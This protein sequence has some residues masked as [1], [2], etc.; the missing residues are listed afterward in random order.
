MNS[1]IILKSTFF[2]PLQTPNPNPKPQKPIS[3]FSIK[4]SI[5]SDPWS[6][7]DGNDISK[8]KPRSRNAKK[9]LSD[10]N[11][12]RIIK[13]K[14]HYLSLLRKNKG[15]HVQTPKWIKRTPEQMVKYLEDHRN[16]QIYGK[17]VI[18]A[19]KTVRGM[20]GVREE[21]RN[22]RLVMSGFVSKLTFREMCVVLKEQRGWREA[23]DFF[24]WMKLQLCYRPCV[25]VYTIVLRI[26]GQV[27]KI[28]L[29]EQTFLEMLESGCEPDEVA[30][31]TMLC[32][33]ARWGRHKA[34]LS[35]YSAIQERGIVLS[36]S[37]YNFMLSSLQKK[38]LHGRVIELWRQM[39]DKG[40]T[41]NSFTYTVVISSLVKDGLHEEAFRMFNEMKN[42]GHVP[43][44]V[45]YSLLITISTKKYNWDE[46]GRLY[47]DLKSQG[48]VPSNFTCA[49]LLTMYYK[50]G[51]FSKA[52]SLFLEMQSKRIPADE[53]IYG[54]LIRIYGKLGL[55]D[56][57]QKIFEET[58]ELG[59]LSDE[60]TYL[61]MA[62]VHLNS[63]NSEKAL[64]VIEVMKS[65]NIWLSR[66]AYIVLLQCYVMKEDLNSAEA[67]FQALSKTGLPDAGSCNDILNLYL[68]LQLTEKAKRFITQIRQDRVHFDEELFKTATKILCN[69]GIL[70]DVEQLTKEM[71]TNELLKDSRFFLTFFQI[72]YGEDKES[73]NFLAFGQFDTLTLRYILTLYLRHGNSSKIEEIMKLLLGTGGG[74]SVVNQLTRNF[75][76]EGDTGKAEALIAQ[77]TKL[78]GRLDDEVIASLISLCGKR[79]KLN[80]A[81]EVFAA[82]ADSPL[83][84]KPIVNSM[85][86]AYAKCGKSEDA[87]SL[88]KEVTDK[89]LNLGAVGVTIF[90]KALSDCG[91]HREA[92]RIVRTSIQDM[93]L[94]TVAY[95]VFIKAMLEAGRLHFAASIYERMIS[96]GV[97]PSIQTYN[98]MI[99]VY[100][101]GDKLDKAVEMFNTACCMGVS[102]DEKAYTN[103]ISYYGKAGKKHEASLLFTKMQE[104]GIKPG[105]VSYNIMINVY[106]RAGLY[107]EAEELFQA[108]QRD[109]CAPDSTTCLLLIRAYTKSLKYLE[110]EEIIDAMWKK[111]ILPSCS[112][113]N[114]LLFAYA[115][116]GLVVEAERVFKKLSTCGLSPDLACYRSMLRGYMDYG[117]V[118][119]GIK[120]FEQMSESVVEPDRFIMSAAVH[121]YKFAGKDTKAEVLLGS[122]NNMKMSFLNN[123][124]VGAKVVST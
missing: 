83:C 78:G 14:A 36:V 55:Y 4:S 21:E 62:Q 52:L 24:F 12:R 25:I 84:G 58:A 63:G 41:P 9:P 26:Y 74:L 96:V 75:I 114:H 111:G 73:K 81:Q 110:A 5:H 70:S 79:Q 42:S 18:A 57:A 123:L 89:G 116:A 49:S 94:D 103:M 98:T 20:A 99:S 33:Y 34:M 87:Y 120:F 97:T 61:A 90:V 39:M 1:S 93:E 115:D 101:R 72:I 38:S 86:D 54:L 66:F 23:R 11:A 3:K 80:Q 17:H 10:D 118:E 28:K 68:K 13:A 32:S 48:L 50:N 53:V 122:M 45:T 104:E 95:N 60:K 37:V 77:V 31:G 121:L 7:S 106:A 67:T 76:R 85:I 109:G 108:M 119:E 40:V 46:A 51:D 6:L 71:S 44:E 29:A 65:R 27:G 47:E 112:H 82:T 88:Y 16:G 8:P 59:L 100:G 102:L 124:Q 56:D 43:E 92:E 91:K 107:R 15:P 35:F 2:S 30:C 105:K 22:V 69:W 113:F 64:Y 117:Y 19:I